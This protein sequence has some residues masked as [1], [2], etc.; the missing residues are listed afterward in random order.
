M[1]SFM[2]IKIAT[3]RQRIAWSMEEVPVTICKGVCVFC[4]LSFKF[5]WSET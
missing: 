3:D 4:G 1:K 2:K 5:K